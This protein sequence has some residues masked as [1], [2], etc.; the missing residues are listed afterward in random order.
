MPADTLCLKEQG[1]FLD[2]ATEL[3]DDG[4]RWGRFVSVGISNE[5]PDAKAQIGPQ[6]PQRLTEF[7]FRKSGDYSW[8]SA[9]WLDYLVATGPPKFFMSGIKKHCRERIHISS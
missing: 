5:D 1:L 4:Q 2:W 7:A 8:T 3:A 9:F 6:A